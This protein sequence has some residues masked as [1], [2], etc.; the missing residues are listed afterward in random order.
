MLLQR[1]FRPEVLRLCDAV[2]AGEPD[3]LEVSGNLPAYHVIVVGDQHLVAVEVQIVEPSVLC[4]SQGTCALRVLELHTEATELQVV[5][6]DHEVRGA[7][8]VALHLALNSQSDGGLEL[9]K[10]SR[11]LGMWVE[12]SYVIDHLEVEIV[13]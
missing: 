4:L 1:G 12:A 6:H 13:F 3:L 8:L 5:V 11:H 7:L 10:S 9:A 2:G